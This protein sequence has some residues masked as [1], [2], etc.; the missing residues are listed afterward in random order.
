MKADLFKHLFVCT[1]RSVFVLWVVTTA[2]FFMIR[3]VPGGPFDS[4]RVVDADI[5]AQLNT[6]YGLDGSAWEQY[7]NYYSHL[8]QGDLGPSFKIPGLRVQEIIKSKLPVSFELGM[9][10]FSLAII[11]GIPLGLLAAFYKNT[12]IERCI[13]I[14]SL[15]GISLP[16]FVIGPLLVLVFAV[17]YPWFHASGF[18]TWGDRVLPTIALAAYPI[19]VIIRLLQNSV[20]EISQQPYIRTAYAKGLSVFKIY[21]THILKNAI[22]PVISYSGPMLAGL[23]SGSFVVENV[24]NI[25]G[26]GRFFIQAAFNRDYT[27]ILGTIL[28]YTFF[29]CVFNLVTEVILYYLNPRFLKS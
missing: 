28:F 19:S 13:H 1:L 2:T 5:M 8:L 6:Y 25:P 3:W 24:F 15:L 9:Y 10:A 12:F 16:N 7:K 18:K 29:L 21:S 27:L 11:I 14:L 20:I 23:L 22:M 4:E 26:L 17:Y